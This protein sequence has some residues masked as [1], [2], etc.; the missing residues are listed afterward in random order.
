MSVNGDERYIK[1][2]VLSKVEKCG[3]CGREYAYENVS[4]LGHE[5]ELWFLMVVCD[6]CHSRG[7]I[8]ALIKDQKRSEVISDL[9]EGEADRIAEKVTVDDVISIREFLKDFNGDFAS[10]FGKKD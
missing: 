8:A 2:I 4:V 6:G 7:L 3:A 10:L 5:D 1:E 9:I